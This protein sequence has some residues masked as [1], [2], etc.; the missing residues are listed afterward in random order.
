MRDFC[1]QAGHDACSQPAKMEVLADLADRWRRARRSACEA[2]LREAAATEAT[3]VASRWTAATQVE[4]RLDDDALL[5]LALE[6]CGELTLRRLFDV[7]RRLGE[8]FRQFH[9]VDLPLADLARTLPVM[10][11]ACAERVW[12]DIPDDA[13]RRGARSGCELARVHPRA[14]EAYREALQGLVTGLSSSVWFARHASRGAGDDECVDVL[15]VHPQSP[16]RFGPIPEALR[17]G[18][19]AARRTACA[20]DPALEIELLGVSE[21][22]LYYRAQRRGGVAEGQV[23]SSFEHHVRRR[24]P[25]LALREMSPRPVLSPDAA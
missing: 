14:C 6:R 5:A 2:A 17:A 18:L 10:G 25:S 13:A 24:F 1:A 8:G 23:T 4:E 12:T 20:L 9:R 16:S 19:D 7:S 22:V 15:H 3:E 21:G 11:V